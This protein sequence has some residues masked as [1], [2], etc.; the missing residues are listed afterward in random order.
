MATTILVHA[1]PYLFRIL[2]YNSMFTFVLEHLRL[3]K[4]VAAG[5]RC[6]VPIF[7][8]HFSVIWGYTSST[9]QSMEAIYDSI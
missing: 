7:A 2:C 3:W 8:L 9:E 6:V 1:F 4:T 5:H